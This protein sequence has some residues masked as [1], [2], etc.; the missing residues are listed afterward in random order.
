MP[1]FPWWVN[2]RRYP[3]MWC[4]LVRILISI[5]SSKV[6]TVCFLPSS[7]CS[8]LQTLFHGNSLTRSGETYGV[9]CAAVVQPVLHKSKNQKRIQTATSILIR[10]HPIQMTLMENALAF[11]NRIS[12][13]TDSLTFLL[14]M[15]KV[16]AIACG[17]GL[18]C[19][20]GHF[21]LST[22]NIVSTGRNH[23]ETKH[24]LVPTPGP[25]VGSPN[26]WGPS[27]F[28]I[29]SYNSFCGSPNLFLH[30]PTVN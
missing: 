28:S 5:C 12:T 24:N 21:Q 27:T 10:N 11:N 29:T 16:K 7:T 25:D 8:S 15:E 1:G 30:L 19:A 20:S 18:L 9:A 17:L 22:F 13:Y 6:A 4:I 14:G 26:T 3:L 2:S 23:L